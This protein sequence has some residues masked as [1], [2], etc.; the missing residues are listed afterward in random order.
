[1]TTTLATKNLPPHLL[2]HLRS[3]HGLDSRSSISAHVGGTKVSG[4]SDADGSHIL[5]VFDMERGPVIIERLPKLNPFAWDRAT[6]L[7]GAYAKSAPVGSGQVG[8]Y[9][10]HNYSGLSYISLTLSEETLTLYFNL[11]M[12]SAAAQLS[13]VE[14][15]VLLLLANERGDRRKRAF[16]MLMRGSRLDAQV[17]L[18]ALREKGLIGAG[19]NKTTGMVTSWAMK[20][21]GREVASQFG[22]GVQRELERRFLGENY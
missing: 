9:S 22:Y 1:M 14:K 12:V 5:S 18:H 2:Q 4:E 11:G 19:M 15:L 8:V 17:V 21:E 16:D 20:P 7:T 10:S 13:D 3:T 6:A